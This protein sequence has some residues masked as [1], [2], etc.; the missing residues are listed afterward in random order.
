MKYLLDTHTLIW[1]IENDEKLS[2][3]AKEIICNI[4]NDCYV[5]IV[6]LW[7]IAIKTNIGKLDFTTSFYQLEK[8]L[9]DNFIIIAYPTFK[10]FS[11][12]QLLPHHHK[13][14]FDRLIIAQ[15]I[16]NNFTILTKDSLFKEY[17]VN[18]IF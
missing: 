11:E 6:S 8:I 16:S 13:D 10:D 18:S 3:T 9:D 12:Y 17:N 15:S 5:S 14:P 4:E 2:S 7:E 1:F